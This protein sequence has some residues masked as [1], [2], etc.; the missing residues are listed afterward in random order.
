MFFV[1]H[2]IIV[3]QNLTVRLDRETIRKAKVLAARRD[4]SVSGLLTAQIQALAAEEDGYD[5]AG[6]QAVALLERPLDLGGK[7]VDR[8]SLHDR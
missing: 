1:L 4:T 3:Q 7:R 2:I 8:A 5:L 6:R